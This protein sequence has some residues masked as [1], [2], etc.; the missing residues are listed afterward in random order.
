M[1]KEKVFHGIYHV[2][3]IYLLINKTEGRRGAKAQCLPANTAYRFDFREG[4]IDYFT[5]FFFALVTRQ[6]WR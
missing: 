5:Y 4:S 1:S 3:P 2:L 6:T